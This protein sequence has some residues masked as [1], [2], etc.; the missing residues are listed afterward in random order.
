MRTTR[1]IIKTLLSNIGSR[2][3]VDQYLTRFASVEK[4]QFAII[5]V[6]GGILA[7]PES[8]EA[9]ASSLTF[10]THVGLV[11]IVVHGAGPQLS[12]ALAEAG[13]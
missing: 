1:D 12:A 13:V 5:K 10:L 3:E 6:G 11:P 2:K 8:L 9:L 4:S 7:D